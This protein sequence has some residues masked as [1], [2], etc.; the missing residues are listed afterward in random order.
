VQLPTLIAH[1]AMDETTISVL[2]DHLGDILK[3][4]HKMRKQL[5]VSEYQNAS[6]SYVSI[7]N[8]N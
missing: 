8:G 4:I 5:F 7:V 6:P 3:Y 1:T 2:T